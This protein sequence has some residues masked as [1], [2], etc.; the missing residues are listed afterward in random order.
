[1]P[2]LMKQYEDKDFSPLIVMVDP[3]VDRDNMPDVNTIE[4]AKVYIENLYPD[5]IAIIDIMVNKV[6]LMSKDTNEIIK[7][8]V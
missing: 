4:E 3:T 6:F 5:T 2:T 1:M 7:T 8:L